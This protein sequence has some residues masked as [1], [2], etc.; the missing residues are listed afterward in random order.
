MPRGKRPARD[1]VHTGCWTCRL[2]HK[3][4]DESLPVCTNCAALEISCHY[5]NEKPEWMQTAST[6]QQMAQQIKADIKRNAKR[7]RGRALIQSIARDI[8]DNGEN[9][10]W[11]DNDPASQS[12]GPI[13]PGFLR[14]QPI[15]D[16]PTDNS[17]PTSGNV[18]PRHPF[19]DISGEDPLTQPSTALGT[20]EAF[21]APVT[22]SIPTAQQN[23]LELSLLLTHLDYVFPVL[24]PFYRPNLLEGGRSWLLV[25]AMRRDAFYHITISLTSYFMS[26]VPVLRGQE[27]QLCATKVLE[28]LRHQMLRS[29]QSVQERL[30]DISRRGVENA[31]FDSA[32]L[33]V[34]IVQLVNFE[35]VMGNSANWQMHLNAA[36]D[37]F[38][39]II[40]QHGSSQTTST[41]YAILDKMTPRSWLQS[42]CLYTADQAAFRFFST[43][44]LVQDIISST[45]LEQSPKI[46]P[47]H[48][49]LLHKD[50][51]PSNDRLLEVKD[52][53]GCQSWALLLIGEIATLGKWK[54]DLKRNSKLSMMELVRRASL[55]EQRLRDG[56]ARLDTTQSS[57]QSQ[58]IS[59]LKGP[60]KEIMDRSNISFSAQPQEAEMIA[61]MTRIW[62]HAA[63]T[64]LLIVLS[65]WQPA[66]PEVRESIT[67]TIALFKRVTSPTW[68]R[69]LAWPFCV[70]G[71]LATEDEEPALREIANS[72][73]ALS[74]FGTLHDALSIMENVWRNRHQLDPDTWDIAACLS[75]LGH[76]VLLV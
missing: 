75:S 66:S 36:L 3:R 59:R 68:L 76:K 52:F 70:T 55:I 21:L 9:T 24:F 40:Q 56:I 28:E 23:E 51:G 12:P 54:K 29:V 20:P 33:L 1:M 45:S 57:Q 25:L 63:H 47:Y 35:V 2:R 5:S 73:G 53:V 19:S 10:L 34:S 39:Q 17:S 72:A 26:V 65:G 16:T 27:H 37:L 15:A 50:D 14:S 22:Q 6:Q 71:C 38:T 13:D 8:S 30:Q 11:S 62:A 44:L 60:L 69:M 67:Q 4:C 61:L 42:P 43:M 18:R 31:L 7:R 49:S 58:Q 74:S 46:Y 41:V 32:C 48:G 64:Y